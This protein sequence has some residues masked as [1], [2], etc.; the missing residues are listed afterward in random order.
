MMIL[1]LLCLHNFVFKRGEGRCYTQLVKSI[2]L[3]LL[4][5]SATDYSKAGN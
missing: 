3:Q 1:Y 5:E 4:R 2:R